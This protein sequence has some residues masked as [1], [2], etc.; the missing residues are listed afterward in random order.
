MEPA[1]GPADLPHTQGWQATVRC[2]AGEP[3]TR[4]A[5]TVR[6]AFPP[7]HLTVAKPPLLNVRQ[8]GWPSDLKVSMLSACLVG[9]RSASERD[10]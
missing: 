5:Q 2:A 10:P 9:Y 7:L 4:C 3:Q 6:P 8:I 1:R